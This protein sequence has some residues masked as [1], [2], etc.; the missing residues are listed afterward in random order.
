MLKQSISL[1]ALSALAIPVQANTLKE[2]IYS[3]PVLAIVSD[4]GT[5][6]NF[7]GESCKH[8]FGSYSLKTDTMT[9]CLQNHEDYHTLG[10]TIRHE[11]IHVV[12][13]CNRG[14]VLSV[15][16]TMDYA[17]PQD[18]AF[19]EEYPHAHQHAELE[20]NIAARNLSD[21]QVTELVTKYCFE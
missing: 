15:M 21:K 19:V 5:T 2:Y 20:A 8:A 14:P 16:T 7:K 1:I 11:A 12:Q 6:I 18:K 13:A 17:T 3:N 9:I 4:T 10:D